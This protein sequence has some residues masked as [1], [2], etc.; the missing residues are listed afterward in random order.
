MYF[1]K[2]TYI[3]LSGKFHIIKWKF[4]FSRKVHKKFC[5]ETK[6]KSIFCQNICMHLVLWNTNLH[7]LGK[8]NIIKY[9]NVKCLIKVLRALICIILHYAATEIQQLSWLDYNIWNVLSIKRLIIK[10]LLWNIKKSIHQFMMCI[11]YLW[12]LIM[13]S[14]N[15]LIN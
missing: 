15:D 9:E 11:K 3:S 10:D 14:M 5:V 13:S 4:L 8:R 6:K 1:I 12:I 2:Y 7:F